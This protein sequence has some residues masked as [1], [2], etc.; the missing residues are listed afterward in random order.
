MGCLAGVDDLLDHDMSNSV[1]I[2]VVKVLLCGSA[3]LWDRG[4]D[5]GPFGYSLC[6]GAE[7]RVDLNVRGADGF[8]RN[9]E[10]IHACE[11]QSR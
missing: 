10:G 6:D 8:N 5:G 2:K 7:G 3:D 11:L 1:L 4:V 9:V